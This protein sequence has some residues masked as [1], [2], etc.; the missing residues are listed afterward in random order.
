MLKGRTLG[1][2]LEQ[3]PENFLGKLAGAL[4]PFPVALEVFSM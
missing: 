2:L 4:H 3:G 1:H